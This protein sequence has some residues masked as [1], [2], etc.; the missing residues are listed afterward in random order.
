[1]TWNYFKYF[2]FSVI[3]AEIIIPARLLRFSRQE[4]K[5][6]IRNLGLIYKYSRKR[7]IE[8]ALAPSF[9]Y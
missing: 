9:V 1:V 4:P 3:S 5:I 8:D 6:V 2:N 7:V